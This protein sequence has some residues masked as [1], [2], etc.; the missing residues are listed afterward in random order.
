[1]RKCAGASG[2]QLDVAADGGGVDGERALVGEAQQIVRTARLGPGARKAL[3]PEGLYA[4]YCTDHVAVHVSV[5]HGQRAEQVLGEALHAAMDAEREAVA[6]AADRGEHL[7][8]RAAAITRDVQNRS[9][10]FGPQLIEPA[11]LE[12][13]RGKE[14]ARRRH[15]RIELAGV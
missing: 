7:R 6:A 10:L 1:M 5:A 3:P 11:Q 9:E 12:Q 14:V 15:R 2:K 4:D 8:Q 13:L